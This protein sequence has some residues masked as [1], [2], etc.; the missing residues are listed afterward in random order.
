MKCGDERNLFFERK[1]LPSNFLKKKVQSK[2]QGRFLPRKDCFFCFAKRGEVCFLFPVLLSG[3]GIWLFQSYLSP[4]LKALPKELIFGSNLFLKGL[5]F[6]SYLSPC[7]T[8]ILPTSVTLYSC[9][10]QSYLSPCLKTFFLKKEALPRKDCFL[11]RKKRRALFFI[12][13]LDRR[14]RYRKPR[15]G[16]LIV[17]IL[18]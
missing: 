7:L 4:G 13:C 8:A 14:G 11:L 18:P 5:I 16:F 6:Q 3:E 12:P 9:I 2:N 10:F 15:R 17:S 1:A